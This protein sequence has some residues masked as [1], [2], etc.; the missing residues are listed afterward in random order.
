MAGT[1]LFGGMFITTPADAGPKEQNLV[2]EAASTLNGFLVDPDYGALKDILS[3]ARGIMIIPDFIK[4][5]LVVGG[6][7]GDGILLARGTDGR[8]SHPAFYELV[9]GSVGL[10]AGASKQEI[11][12]IIMTD[13][14]LDSL[15]DGELTF[16]GGVAVA[17][18]PTGA[19]VGAPVEKADIY[20][21]SRSSW[22][23]AGLVVNGGRV[24]ADNGENRRYYGAPT[25]PRSILLDRK[26][27][28][29]GANPLLR[30]LGS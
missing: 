18:G 19:E 23:Y 28:N 24:A 16:G 8:W 6:Q 29:S 11:L 21:Y 13:K 30:L 14:V 5:G 4:A 27:S 10:Q 12:M 20:T 17:A 15:L 3:R 26:H 25:T 22:A 7:S 1:V 2:N 9:G